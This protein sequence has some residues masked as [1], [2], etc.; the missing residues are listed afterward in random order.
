MSCF[1]SCWHWSHFAS[2]SRQ[3]LLMAFSEIYPI[4]H[5]TNTI[6]HQSNANAN[7]NATLSLHII[8]G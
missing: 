6:C 1:E 8:V 7:A 2:T 3:S 4:N 5:F